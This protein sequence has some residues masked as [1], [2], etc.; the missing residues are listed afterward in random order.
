MKFRLVVVLVLGAVLAGCSVFGGGTPQT[1]PTVVL[2]SAN[3]TPSGAAAPARSGA[4]TASG[5]VAP[6]RQVTLA[7]A[8]SGSILKLG[9][10]EGDT[11]QA[12]Q[13]LV[14]LSGSEKLAAAV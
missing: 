10:A 14:N 4:V 6:G 5:V 13:A 2:D 8:A 7:A 9:A 12:G 11:V 3:P 1:L